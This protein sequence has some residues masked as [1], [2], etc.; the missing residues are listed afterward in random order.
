MNFLEQTM[1]D[2]PKKLSPYLPWLGLLCLI[3]GVGLF[4]VTQQWDLLTN[5][6]FA[7]GVVFLLLYALINPDEVRE[8]M[9][10]RSAQYGVSTLLS[11]LFFTAIVVLLYFLAFQNP[12][13]RYDATETGEFTP[14]DE[15]VSLVESLD[16]PIHVIGFFTI[17]GAFQQT[18]AQTRLESLQAYTDQ[19]SF[20]FVDPE[21]NPVLAEQYD[22]SFNNTLVFTRGEGENEVFSKAAAPLNDRSLHTALVQVVNPTDKKAYF[23]TGHG[24]RSITDS[25]A[26]G[27]SNAASVLEEAG[28]E[29]EEIGL[30]QAEEIPADATALVMI[31]Q[32]AP[33]SDAELALIADYLATGGAMLIARDALDS[34]IRAR[35]EQQGND[36]VG[37]YLATTWGVTLRTDVVI[38]P[39]FTAANS[40]LA[41]FSN[42]FGASPITTGDLDQFG[43]IFN[44]ARSLAIDSTIEGLSR[45][46]LISTGQNAWGESNFDEFNQPTGPVPNEGDEQGVLT[47]AVSLEDLGTNGR[48]IVV[49]DTDVFSNELLFQA[50]NWQLFAN[51]L[52]W[53]ADD[54]VAIDLT[55]RETVDRQL[56][57]PQ[58]QLNLVV[59]M[60]I[61]LGPLVAMV[62]GGIVWYSRRQRR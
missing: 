7:L 14:L 51:A 9:S 43:I 42:T 55:P 44:I 2:L 41:F 58:T 54:E 37:D 34:D 31:D 28:F 1:N 50:G 35:L 56:S 61:C 36:V 39:D 30:F 57:I 27:M 46:N 52:N 18:E 40:F 6:T 12:D 23:I 13:W 17:Q 32:Q 59:L 16:E 10:G 29:T 25:S 47:L 11:S 24:E 45:V 21:A 4:Y 48:L 15:T 19:I 62:A 26:T 3:G 53:L 60:T 33:I 5:L 20:E 8:L 22:L 49:G 38:D